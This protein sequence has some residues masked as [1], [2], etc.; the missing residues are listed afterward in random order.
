MIVG[1][2]R[3]LEARIRLRIRGPSGSERQI[4]AIVDSGF[5]GCLT[6]PRQAIAPCH[7]KQSRRSA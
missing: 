2:V 5:T 6:L 3:T 7:V 1:I 4:E